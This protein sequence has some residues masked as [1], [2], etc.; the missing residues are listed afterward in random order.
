MGRPAQAWSTGTPPLTAQGA[1]GSSGLAGRAVVFTALGGQRT[2]A[3]RL[4][5]H[6][7]G[8]ST[9]TAG[10][11]ASARRLLTLLGRHAAVVLEAPAVTSP[12]L[13]ALPSLARQDAVLVRVPGAT[14]ID[15]IRLLARGADHVTSDDDP[16][17]AFAV[18]GAA[19]RR[20]PLSQDMPPDVVHVGDICV[21]LRAR[22]A[23]LAGR[24]L[25]LTALEFDLLAYFLGHPGVPLSRTRLLADVWGYDVGGLET[26]TVHVRRLRTK[27]EVDP[28]RPMRLQTVWGVGY[29]LRDSLEAASAAPPG[30]EA[31][32]LP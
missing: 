28:S 2:E 32:V 8:A 23:T 30:R 12:L 13:E 3:L 6:R 31:V 17:E 16:E 1:G 19:L 4:I 10:D 25:R 29:R 26:V 24:T 21:H 15:R 11:I 14:R 5:L 20:T 27:I 18:L 22:V 9:H 7:A